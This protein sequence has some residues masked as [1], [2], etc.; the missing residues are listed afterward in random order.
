MLCAATFAHCTD[1][2]YQS[3]ARSGPGD[4]LLAN[5]VR[6]NFRVSPVSGTQDRL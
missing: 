2:L 1:N 6:A 4:P 5:T 3:A